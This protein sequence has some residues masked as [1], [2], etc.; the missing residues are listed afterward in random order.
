MDFL[1]RWYAPPCAAV[2]VWG[3][4]L[5]VGFSNQSALLFGLLAGG[6]MLALYIVRTVLEYLE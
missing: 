3:I 5:L 1:M 4:L 6:L 2:I